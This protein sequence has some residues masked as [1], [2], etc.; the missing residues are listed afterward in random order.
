MVAATDTSGDTI[1]CRKYH[2]TLATTM[3][4]VPH[5]WHA[6]PYGYDGCG[7][8]CDSFCKITLGYCSA[9]G[10]FTGTPPYATV[11]DCMTECNTLV[12]T[13]KAAGAAG[14]Y[15]SAGTGDT[16]NTIECRLYHLQNALKNPANQ[17]TH[18]PHTGVTSAACH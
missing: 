8:I 4:T 18:C 2:T 9:A 13:A 11:A 6:G 10:G 15:N 1:G 5:C 3:G 7:S 16:G 17:T 14:D 12:A